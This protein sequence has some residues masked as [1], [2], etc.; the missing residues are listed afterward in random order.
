MSILEWHVEMG[1]DQSVFIVPPISVDREYDDLVLRVTGNMLT[2]QKLDI[3][4][5]ICETLNGG[6]ND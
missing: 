2:N 4:D 5:K 1:D 6:N 3:A